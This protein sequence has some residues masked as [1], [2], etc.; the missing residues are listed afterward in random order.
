M[1]SCS[2][3]PKYANIYLIDVYW[4]RLSRERLLE[5]ETYKLR[6]SFHSIIMNV[7][8][9]IALNVEFR[10]SAIIMASGGSP[11]FPLVVYQPASPY[12]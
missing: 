11:M 1:P 10:Y 9:Q 4:S 8:Y 7:L 2:V 12:I 6:S 5:E 3:L